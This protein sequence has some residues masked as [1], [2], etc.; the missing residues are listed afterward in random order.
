MT[1]HTLELTG[2]ADTFEVVRRAMRAGAK[3]EPKLLVSEWADK[4]RMLTTRSSPEPG[5]WITARTPYL[6][7]VMDSLSPSDPTERVV[8]MKGSQ[9]GGTE[10]GNNWVGYVIHHAPGPMMVVQPT[11]DM[12]KRNSRQRI[13]PLIESSPALRGL[14]HE[15][16]SRDSSNTILVK[17]FLGGILVMTGANS[18]KGLR[19][20][21]VRYLFLDEVDGYKPDVDREGDPCELAITRTVNFPRRKIFICSTPTLDGQSNIQRFFEESDQR[22][23]NVPCPRCSRLIVFY[24]EQLQWSR[25]KSQQAAYFCQHCE[26]EI[27]DRE[28]TEMFAA[29]KW[30]P[31]AE[32][33]GVTRG[34]HLSSYYS[35]NGWLSW[36]QILYKRDQAQK[37]NKIQHF[38]NTILGLPF[39]GGGDAP[40]PDRLYERRE[41]YLIGEVPV[42]GVFLT[43]GADVQPNRIEVEVVAW[44]R[45]K[46]SW[47]VDYRVLMGNTNQPEVW[48]E[49]TDLMDEDFPTAAGGAMRIAKMAVDSGFN[50]MAVYDWVRGMLAQRVMCVKGEARVAS[51]VGASSLIEV[52]PGGRAIK[53][54]IR[55]HPVNTSI[56]KEELY[57][58]LKSPM[59]DL[60]AGEAWPTGYCHFPYYSK[61]YFEQLC[62]ERL[63][64]RTVMGRPHTHWEKIRDR[65]EA[66]DCRLYSRAAAVSMRM[67]GWPE[68]KWQEMERQV[69]TAPTRPSAARP[70]WMDKPAPT[71][72]P[73]QGGDSFLD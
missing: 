21:A 58:W 18:A 48:R 60:D 29:G 11:V 24:P 43:A 31:T 26:G 73:M 64:T 23:Y 13:A 61:E 63:V 30:I 49:L 7:E 28:K 40:E 57:R 34:Y 62:A 46:Q 52:G 19:S 41:N 9:I 17:E 71:F 22:Y 10:C 20:M 12:A 38:W 25:I 54:G 2:L 27:Y 66:L 3:P 53:G 16:R 35:P 51:L 6:K 36:T 50:T 42:G 32:G 68:P 8:L 59:P 5:H 44:G 56:A 14:V 70:A 33:D 47:S 15:P 1:E 65:N 72:K 37:T 4:H 45:N 39:Q 69:A 55:L 67:D